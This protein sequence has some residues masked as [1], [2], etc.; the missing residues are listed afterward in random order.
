[1][2][3]YVHTNER[4]GERERLCVHSVCAIAASATTAFDDIQQCAVFLAQGQGI[5]PHSVCACL[6]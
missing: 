4:Y 3:V 6:P 5:M 2:T 1:M